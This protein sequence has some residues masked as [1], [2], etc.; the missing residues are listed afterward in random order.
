MI[1]PYCKKELFNISNSKILKYFDCQDDDHSFE[2]YTTDFNLSI[3]KDKI[4]WET[5]CDPNVAWGRLYHLKIDEVGYIKIN[6]PIYEEKGF[7]K[8]DDLLVPFINKLIK[9]KAFL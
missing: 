7:R 9:I 3:F 2:H 8:A 5:Y 1:C 6:K 4:R